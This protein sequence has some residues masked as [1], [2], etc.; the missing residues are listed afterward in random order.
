M[1]R[2]EVFGSGR[3]AKREGGKMEGGRAPQKD[4]AGKVR[5]DRH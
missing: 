1:R 2:T 4:D 3:S 5:A